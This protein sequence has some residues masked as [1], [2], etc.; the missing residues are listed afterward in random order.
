MIREGRGHV[1]AKGKPG[2]AFERFAFARQREGLQ[3][4][5]AVA[6]RDKE[7][8]AHI[9]SFAL[10]RPDHRTSYFPNGYGYKV[11]AERFPS[12][13]CVLASCYEMKGELVESPQH[14]PN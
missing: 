4:L 14:I 12:H 6:T 3:R 13:V 1:R 9:E 7:I 10:K 5:A 8:H 2:D 11:I